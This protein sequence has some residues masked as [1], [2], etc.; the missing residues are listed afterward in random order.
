MFYADPDYSWLQ[1]S[2][3]MLEFRRMLLVKSKPVRMAFGLLERPVLDSV[4]ANDVVRTEASQ[5]A[6][7]RNPFESANE[8]PGVSLSASLFRFDRTRVGP[9]KPKARPQGLSAPGQRRA[10]ARSRK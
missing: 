4:D 1:Q 2:C 8:L 5:L 7:W 9:D 10:Q 3:R 6:V